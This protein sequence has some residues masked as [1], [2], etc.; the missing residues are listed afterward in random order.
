[1]KKIHG[2]KFNTA[3]NL[4]ICFG[5]VFQPA[6]VKAAGPLQERS[7]I[8]TMKGKPVTLL[9]PEIMI[10]Q[11]APDFIAQATDLSDVRLSDLR[12]KIKLIA[13]VPSLD[14]PVCDAEIHRFNQEAASVSRN[15]EILLPVDHVVVQKVEEGAVSRVEG[16]AISE[17]WLGVDIGPKTVRDSC[18]SQIVFFSRS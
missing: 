16:P 13:S 14:T 17:G 15:V 12:D 6:L 2:G 8:V 7:G 10:G 18:R 4:T 3:L 5:M 9:G 1:M 11:T